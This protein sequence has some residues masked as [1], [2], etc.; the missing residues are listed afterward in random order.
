MRSEFADLGEADCDGTFKIHLGSPFSIRKVS[1]KLL[2]S[3]ITMVVGETVPM[4]VEISPT[5]YHFFWVNVFEFTNP[6]ET[7]QYK[8]VKD[9]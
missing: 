2:Q 5:K 4:Y 6:F 9:L 7:K 8:D 1:Y 3:A